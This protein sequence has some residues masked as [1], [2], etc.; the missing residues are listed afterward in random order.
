ME[1]DSRSEDYPPPPFIQPYN[2]NPVSNQCYEDYAAQPLPPEEPSSSLSTVEEDSYVQLSA[3]ALPPPPP[4]TLRPPTQLL[5]DTRPTTCTATDD[6]KRKATEWL[7]PTP[8]DSDNSP[9]P[10]GEDKL[11]LKKRTKCIPPPEGGIVVSLLDADL[12][13]NFKMVGNEMIVTKPGR[14]VENIRV[15]IF[16][17]HLLYNPEV[18]R[19][20]YQ[21]TSVSSF[22]LFVTSIM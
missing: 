20:T 18:V 21:S 8:V 17:M 22:S 3:A 6:L 13:N 11:Q 4:P 7:P 5:S 9:S 12:W 1:P 2:C 10:P 15:F 16:R 14:W 19:H